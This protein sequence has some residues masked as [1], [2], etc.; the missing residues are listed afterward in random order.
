MLN[1]TVKSKY[2]LSAVVELAFR[3]NSGSMQIKALAES[4]GIPQNFL[5]Q[6]LVDLKQAGLVI[7]FRGSQ[8]GYAL[9]KSPDAITVREVLEALSGKA[10]V[11]TGHKGC[12]SLDFFWED[13]EA[14]INAIFDMTISQLISDKQRR[15]KMLTF[16]I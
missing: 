10:Q 8:G 3:R 11:A 7:S 15:E 14:K 16:T 12:E 13:V 5:E 9:A 6:L 1:I 2:G 4:N